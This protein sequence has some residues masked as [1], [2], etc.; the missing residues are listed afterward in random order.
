M[1]IWLY[2]LGVLTLMTVGI[3]CI[4]KFGYEPVPEMV[5]KPSKFASAEEIGAAILRRFYAPVREEKVIQIGIPSQPEWYQ[6]FVRGFLTTAA[7]EKAPF[8]V[9]LVESQLPAFNLVGAP[10]IDLQTFDSNSSTQAE[11]IDR[12]RELRATGKHVLLLTSSVYS[13]HL[14][15]G[16]PTD[17]YEKSTGE[18]LFSITAGPLALGASEEYRVTPPCLGSERDKSGT[19]ALGC[20]ILKASRGYY[21]KMIKNDRF[22][23]IMNKPA[24]DDYLLMISPPPGI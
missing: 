1:K 15:P 14:L 24:M 11:M 13:S 23:A 2:A 20:A 16:N 9:L 17:R 22:V 10:P 5:L 3:F 19:S 18:H 4:L 12:L 7:A 6:G 8:D 21:S